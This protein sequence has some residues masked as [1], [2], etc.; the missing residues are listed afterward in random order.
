[1]AL[2]FAQYTI[3]VSD[4]FRLL[5]LFKHLYYNFFQTRQPCVTIDVVEDF[6]K[7]S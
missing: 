7:D 6:H 1:M 5:A 4:M 2:K 3:L